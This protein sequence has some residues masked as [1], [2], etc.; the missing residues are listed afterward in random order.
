MK[1]RSA[2]K[3]VSSSGEVLP[4]M[5]YSNNKTQEDVVNEALDAIEDYDIVFLVGGV[6][7][8]KNLQSP[9]SNLKSQVKIG[10]RYNTAWIVTHQRVA[11][12]GELAGAA[13]SARPDLPGRGRDG[14]A[15]LAWRAGQSRRRGTG[16]LRDGQ[17]PAGAGERARVRGARAREHPRRREESMGGAI[18]RRD[19]GRDLAA[20]SVGGLRRGLCLLGTGRASVGRL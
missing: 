6:G 1:K 14:G 8:G 11:G 18:L 15:G 5:V 4:P 9:I 2:W 13:R 17:L 10:R 16:S 7:T 3:L 12:G 19:D 20:T